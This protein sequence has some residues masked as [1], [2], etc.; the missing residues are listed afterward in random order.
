MRVVLTTPVRI[1]G[2]GG[3]TILPVGTEVDAVPFTGWRPE[4]LRDV[5]YLSVSVKEHPH[6]TGEVRKDLTHP[7]PGWAWRD[8]FCAEAHN[9]IAVEHLL[10]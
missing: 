10:P 3:A 4:W 1:N 6:W 7:A 5:C 9:P 8:E 2:Y